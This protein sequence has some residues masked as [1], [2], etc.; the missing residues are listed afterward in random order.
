VQPDQKEGIQNLL[1]TEIADLSQRVNDNRQVKPA[2]DF[3]HHAEQDPF[4]AKERAVTGTFCFPSL[5]HLF[6]HTQEYFA[7]PAEKTNGPSPF[8]LEGYLVAF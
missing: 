1:S 6:H 8:V 2:K 7:V 4:H 5:F 3:L